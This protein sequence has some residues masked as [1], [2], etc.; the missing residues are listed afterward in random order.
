MTHMLRYP[1]FESNFERSVFFYLIRHTNDGGS[2]E[3]KKE[4]MNMEWYRQLERWAFRALQYVL[5]CSS[6][7]VVPQHTSRSLIS[8]PSRMSGSR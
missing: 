3:R 2:N 8:L 7:H 1:S 6:L 4:D 5:R